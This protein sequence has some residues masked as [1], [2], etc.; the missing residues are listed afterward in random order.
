MKN[1]EQQSQRA[2]DLRER[3]TK[4]SDPIKK[5][6]ADMKNWPIRR[7]VNVGIL[8][9]DPKQGKIIYEGGVPLLEC[10]ADVIRD[11]ADNMSE[12]RERVLAAIEKDLALNEAVA[13]PEADDKKLNE[14]NEQKAKQHGKK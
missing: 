9:W 10:E 14:S 4:I 7:L 6:E 13:V 12:F 3:L 11:A 1:F 5:A 8:S 2:A